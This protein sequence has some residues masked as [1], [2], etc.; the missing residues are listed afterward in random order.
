MICN[1]I[2]V[3]RSLITNNM[4]QAILDKAVERLLI[5]K[6]NVDN[7]VKD[8]KL[9]KHSSESCSWCIY[10]KRDGLTSD[11]LLSSCCEWCYYCI[12]GELRNPGSTGFEPCLSRIA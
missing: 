12:N 10:G 2:I 9:L 3:R 4:Y 7:Y 5:H 8:F 11:D 6:C 1:N